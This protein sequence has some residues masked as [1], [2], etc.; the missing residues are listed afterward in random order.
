MC[1]RQLS[2]RARCRPQSVNRPT[3]VPAWRPGVRLAC[4]S[5]FKFCAL[6]PL[7]P[8]RWLR[9][10]TRARARRLPF[11]CIEGLE[12]SGDR[13]LVLTASRLIRMRANAADAPYAVDKAGQAATGGGGGP[14]SPAVPPQHTQQAGQA[15]LF[16]WEFDLAYATLEGV[17]PLAQQMMVASRLP[18]GEQEEFLQVGLWGWAGGV[19]EHDFGGTA[20]AGRCGH[21]VAL[22]H[23]RPGR[24]EAHRSRGRR[25]A[26]PC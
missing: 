15:R 17:M 24:G 20:G 10:P 5:A 2:G 23:E 9:L 3:K 14:P 13:R 7:K 1:G 21:C 18:A 25:K 16:H 12:G 19:A 4:R 8:L 6:C 22:G 26:G 11:A